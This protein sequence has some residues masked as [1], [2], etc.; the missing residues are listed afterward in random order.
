[1]NVFFVFKVSILDVEKPIFEN[2]LKETSFYV[3]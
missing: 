3:I 1:M 2:L